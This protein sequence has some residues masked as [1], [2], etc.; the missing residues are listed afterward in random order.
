MERK[1]V[2]FLVDPVTKDELEIVEF[3]SDGDNIQS[4]YYL[5]PKTKAIFPIYKGVPIMFANVVNT[6][7]FEQF[8][9]RLT[10]YKANLKVENENYWS[11]S[12]EWEFFSEEKMDKTWAQTL[13]DRYERFLF[14]NRI[15]EEELSHKIILDAGCGNGTHTENLAN[16]GATMVG[17][18][19]SSSVFQAEKN[20]K[21]KNLFF[22][23]GDLQ[24][25]PF[26]ES[27]FDLIISNGV[28]HHTKS[29]YN[30]FLKLVPIVKSGGSLYLW[31]YNRQGNFFWRAKRRFFD[32]S[33]AIVCRL[34]L[35]FQKAIVGFYTAI[36]YGVYK[37]L[38][39][40]MKINK[41]LDIELDYNSLKLSMWDSI[42]P[43]WR[44]Y[45]EPVEL[46][47][48]Y[49]NNGF[50]PPMFTNWESLYGYGVL[51]YKK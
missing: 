5:N 42:T 44:H 28:I 17:I 51:G 12:G 50:H 25:P 33:R 21:S 14:E 43:R 48:W 46:W 45:H 24:N 20:R 30:T 29:T 41:N 7:Y 2:P 26:K 36:L 15:S 9:D 23:K 8:K 49:L 18:D 40:K 37:M 38:N 16:K 10:E 34:P 6:S 27:F 35:S 13:N 19:F 32:I 11:F 4:G 22:V 3:E 31:L 47:Y 1:F 39:K